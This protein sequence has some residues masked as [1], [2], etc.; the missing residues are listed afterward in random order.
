M[1]VHLPR[2]SPDGTKIAFM[3]SRP[4]K[5]WRIL[6]VRPQGGG[7]PLEIS[8]DGANQGDPTWTPDGNSIVFAGMP[9]LEYAKPSGPNIHVI[10]VKTSR[11]SD[12][13][14]SERLFSPRCSPDGRFIAALSDDS[15][16]LMLYDWKTTT[17]SQLAEGP[18]AF[19]NWS[20]DLRHIYAEQYMGKEDDFV[21]IRVPD[22]KVTRIFSLKEVPRGFDPFESWVGLTD[23]Q[24]LLM[25]DRST[26]EIYALDL[27]FP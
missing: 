24:P 6:I 8:Q 14:G 5:P 10:D 11:R 19:Q 26:Q 20:G 13:P 25:R 18:F 2:W 3:A 27:Q 21:S 23:D 9:W 15:K 16:K 4:G 1:K 7:M 12:L 22:G 17:W